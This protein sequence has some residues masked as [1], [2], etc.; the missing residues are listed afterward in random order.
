[1]GLSLA[2]F[3]K[4]SLPREKARREGI[5]SLADEEVLAL[6]LSGGIQG[7]NALDL[8]REL[9]QRYGSFSSLG[10]APNESLMEIKGIKEAKALEIAALFEVARRAAKE[11]PQHGESP[12]EELY[13]HYHLSLE[14]DVGEKGLVL[15]YDRRGHFLKE[16]ILFSGSEDR[17]SASPKMVLSEALSSK[18]SSFV[19]LHNHPSGNPYPSPADF[20][21]TSSLGRK[22]ADLSLRFRDHIIVAD[23]RFFSFREHG[24]L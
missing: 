18:A 12:A 24:L 11:A 10:S 23:R 8:A 21:F 2:S 13:E 9:L 3:P 6:V 1:M 16:K 4:E 14:D 20:S 22:A 5:S 19:F 17:L 7:K 15:L